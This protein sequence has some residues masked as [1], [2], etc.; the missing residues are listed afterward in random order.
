VSSSLYPHLKLTNNEAPYC[1]NCSTASITQA[2]FE[3]LQQLPELIR[4]LDSTA[5][6][7]S[8]EHLGQLLGLLPLI[9]Q[10]VVQALQKMQSYLQVPSAVPFHSIKHIRACV[11][12]LDS[13]ATCMAAPGVCKQWLQLD[14]D[15]LLRGA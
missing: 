5:S 10:A 6:A 13:A 12:L 2:E 7:G 1:L 14:G 4:S 3:S 11:L 9:L 15:E 8:Q